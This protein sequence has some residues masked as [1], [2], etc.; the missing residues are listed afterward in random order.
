M[1]RS[2]VEILTQIKYTKITLITWVHKRK[3]DWNDYHDISWDN[4]KIDIDTN[5]CAPL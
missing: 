5:N 1:N 4:T 2:G 3:Y